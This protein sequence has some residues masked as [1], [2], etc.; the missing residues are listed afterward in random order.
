M[1]HL[2]VVKNPCGLTWQHLIQKG[3]DLVLLHMEKHWAKKNSWVVLTVKSCLSLFSPLA[4]SWVSLF[5]SWMV[6]SLAWAKM[7]RPKRMTKIALFIAN[8]IKRYILC[9]IFKFK[10]DAF[11][12][13]YLI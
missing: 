8:K 9:T 1:D 5:S 11:L 12:S 13:M 2:Q 7:S 6:R 4:I 10:V 3:D